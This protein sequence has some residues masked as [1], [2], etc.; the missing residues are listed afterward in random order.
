MPA[1]T[2]PLQ[3]YTSA[4]IG[5]RLGRRLRSRLVATLLAKDAA[6]FT[7]ARKGDLMQRL[8]TDTAALS[9]A[10]G[11]FVGQRGLRSFVE[12]LASSTCLAAPRHSFFS[13]GR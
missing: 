4:V 6:F 3:V 1:M 12:V 9:A 7:T 13:G 8:T 5:E 11:D 10:A 2:S